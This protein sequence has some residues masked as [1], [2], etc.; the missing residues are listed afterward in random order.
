MKNFFGKMCGC[1][2]VKYETSSPCESVCKVPKRVSW[3]DNVSVR[4]YYLEEGETLGTMKV[5]R[6]EKH[7]KI[8]IPNEYGG[9]VQSVC[10]VDVVCNISVAP[11]SVK[12]IQDP[13]MLAAFGML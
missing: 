3:D 10:G 5:I 4:V 11:V 13:E 7:S 2:T 8:T 12:K 1:V 6:K 9:M